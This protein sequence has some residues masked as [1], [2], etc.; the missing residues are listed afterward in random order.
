[1]CIMEENAATLWPVSELTG[2]CLLDEGSAI[3][4]CDETTCRLGGTCEYDAEGSHGCVCN[5]NCD[6]IRSVKHK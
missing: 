3:E 1:M 5:F 6:A 2:G 4:V